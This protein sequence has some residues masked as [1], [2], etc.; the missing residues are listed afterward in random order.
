MKQNSSM[1]IP[2]NFRH[3]L[4]FE[5]ECELPI[6]PIENETDTKNILLYSQFI[7][8][9]RAFEKD[10]IKP[11][12]HFDKFQ[13]ILMML[14]E[15]NQLELTDLFKQRKRKDARPL[16]IRSLGY[17]LQF[18][19]WS[20]EQPVTDLVNLEKVTLSIKNK[21][22]NL[23]ERLGFIF[24]KPDHYHSYIQLVQL[25]EE[26]VKLYFKEQSIRKMNK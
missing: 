11:W 10:S 9:I 18:L 6:D 26:S 25:F 4:F 15:E 23:N 14:W 5:D 12:E 17:Y 3:S 20:N 7:F 1:P 16:M 8:D 21:P 24:A 22:I 19:C 13:P 2:T